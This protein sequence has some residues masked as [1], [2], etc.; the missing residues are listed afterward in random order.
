MLVMT[1]LMNSWALNE[2]SI[3]LYFTI[4]SINICVS[5]S[6]LGKDRPNAL[7][8][9]ATSTSV[10]WAIIGASHRVLVGIDAA[11]RMTRKRATTSCATRPVGVRKPAGQ[12]R[13]AITMNGASTALS[14]F[15]RLG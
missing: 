2:R 6:S 9:R 1:G 12:K 5:E 11:S 10:T 7:A 8:N 15:D 3:T 4:V 14:R 13:G